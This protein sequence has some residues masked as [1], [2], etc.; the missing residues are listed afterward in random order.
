MHP[1]AP[2]RSF[3]TRNAAISAMSA[4]ILM[5]SLSV[6]A[7]SAQP[8]F[9][10]LV[11]C[12]A[13][14]GQTRGDLIE[15]FESGTPVLASYPDQDQDPDDWQLTTS[16]AFG[17]SGSSLRLYGNTW[18]TQAIT[19]VA[20]ADSTVWQVAIYCENRGEMQ[21]LGVSDGENELFYTFFGMDLPEDTNWYTVYQGAFP[22]DQWHLYLLP[23]G[24]DWEIRFGYTP[25]LDEL[26]Y[27]N[28]ADSG[29]PGITLFDAIA[30]VTTDLSTHPVYRRR[31]ASSQR[32]ALPAGDPV[33]RRG[34]RS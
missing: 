7:A 33:L 20:V 21:A 24:R 14:V 22:R 1:C 3:S 10:R 34:V 8:H 11:I 13:A 5:I 25:D 12:S 2:I 9:A 30:D 16:N 19:P 26:I 15:D 17:G 6:G 28:D 23:I 4:L 31:A 27:V 32:E 29:S 18:K